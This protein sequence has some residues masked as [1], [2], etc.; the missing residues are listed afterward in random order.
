MFCYD[1]KVQTPDNSTSY[2]ANELAPY[3]KLRQAWSCPSF[4]VSGAKISSNSSTYGVNLQHV[5]TSVM[6]SPPPLSLA[7]FS[8]PA[9]LLWMADSQSS[10]L[11]VQQDA[12]CKSFQSGYLAVYCPDTSQNPPIVHSKNCPLME[13]SRA[14]DNRHSGGAN[15]LLVDG[16]ARWVRAERL[17]QPETDANHSVDLWGH[18]SL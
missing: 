17:I 6:G 3:V 13:A 14:V 4:N 5:V 1:V 9:D 11:Y 2:W 10:P 18:W 16:H 8:R 12:S 15:I 7:A